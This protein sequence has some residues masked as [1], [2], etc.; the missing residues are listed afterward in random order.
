MKAFR[1]R[2]PA[3]AAGA[4]DRILDAAESLFASHG[5]AATS[6]RSI[7]ARAGVNLAAVN[8]HFRSKDDLFA[9][10]LLRKIEPINRRRLELLDRAEAAASP[11]VLED[12]LAAFL[13]PVLG[14]GPGGRELS[15]YARLMGRVLAEPGRWAERLFPQ[16]FQPVAE[17]FLRALRRSVGG[18]G[19]ESLVWGAY[20]GVGV[21]AYYAISSGLF[22]TMSRGRAGSLDT[23]VV[24][25]RMIR[26]MAG[27]LRALAETRRVAGQ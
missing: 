9:A 21:M 19:A 15:T 22:E 12:V 24:Q 25:R 2:H 26:Y 1:A 6:L 17:R 13:D 3:P 27:G 5:F 4:K 11:P 23:A 14:S 7:T 18:G 16:A 10:V 8:Y 20:F